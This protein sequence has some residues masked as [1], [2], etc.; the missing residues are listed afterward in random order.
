M[1]LSKV[2]KLIYTLR[3]EKDMTQKQVAD[4]MHISD[5]AISKWERGLGCPDVSL[6][7]ELSF[8]D[9]HS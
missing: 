3:K 9:F 6:L 5:K 1:D 4:L 8:P 7:P 2:G